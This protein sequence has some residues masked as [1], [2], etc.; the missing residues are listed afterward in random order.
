MSDGITLDYSKFET[1]AGKLGIIVTVDL[2]VMMRG[3]GKGVMTEIIKDTP[4]SS[5]RKGR[6]TGNAALQIAEGQIEKTYSLVNIIGLLDVVDQANSVVVPRPFGGRGDL[7]SFKINAVAAR[8]HR[9]FRS[10]EVPPLILIDE[11]LKAGL[12]PF[13]PAGAWMLPTDRYEGF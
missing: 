12:D 8:G 1:A 7:K 11:T 9:N 2:E 4:P 5:S 10:P 13:K 6:R 3:Q